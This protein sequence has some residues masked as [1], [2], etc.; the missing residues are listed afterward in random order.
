MPM[1]VGLPLIYHLGALHFGNSD[2]LHVSVRGTSFHL[3]IS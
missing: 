3:F 1:V 2:Y